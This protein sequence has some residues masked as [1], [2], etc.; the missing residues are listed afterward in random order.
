MTDIDDQIKAALADNPLD[1]PGIIEMA[2]SNFRGRQ[3]FVSLLTWAFMLVMLAVMVWCAV[4]Y[5]RTTD[6]WEMILYATIFLYLSIG[7][8]LMKLWF[9]LMMVRY[10]IVR[11]M[12]RLELQFCLMAKRQSADG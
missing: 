9:W 6:V 4:A 10:S 12:K 7:V 11:E 2:A 1:Q 8:A 3:L 5:F